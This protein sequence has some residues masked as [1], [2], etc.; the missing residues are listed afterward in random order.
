MALSRLLRQ[1]KGILWNGN[2]Y[3]AQAA[4]DDLVMDLD[5]TETD[6]ASI[7]ALRKAAAEFETYITN[8]AD[9]IPNYAE[10]HR[11]G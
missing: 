2:L 3:D 10:R 7:K 4:I 9:M 5:E 8:N 6:Y 11:Y 1:I